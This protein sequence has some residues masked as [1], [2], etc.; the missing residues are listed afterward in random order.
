MAQIN[1]WL[2]IFDTEFCVFMTNFD[3]IQKNWNRLDLI[4]DRVRVINICGK[5]GLAP[6]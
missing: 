1:I 5:L 2:Q 6:A 3:L 4:F